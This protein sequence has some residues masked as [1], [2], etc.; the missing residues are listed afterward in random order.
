M[1]EHLKA[2]GKAV[3]IWLM[4]ILNASVELESVPEVLKRGIVVPVYKGGGKN[5]L[6]A[7]SYRGITLTS[8]MAKVLEFLLLERLH[9][10]FLEAGLPHINQSMYKR[11]VSC[12]DAVFATQEVIAK[13]HRGGSKVYMCLYDLQKAFDSVE[14]QFS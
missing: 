10:V 13:Y 9:L 2:G 11:A 7:N 14:Y 5:P 6:K 12:D 4:K 8:I 3:V 1:T